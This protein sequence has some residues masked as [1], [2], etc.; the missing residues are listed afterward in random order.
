MKEETGNDRPVCINYGC[1]KF[2]TYSVKGR[3]RPFCGRCHKAGFG[4]VKQ[5]RYQQ[6]ADGSITKYESITTYAD[7]VTPFKTGK[8]TNKGVLDLGF[9]CPMDYKKAPWAIGRTELDHKDG[10][11]TNNTIENIQELCSV[12]H[13]EK[14]R[15]N[16]DYKDQNNYKK[17]TNDNGE[18]RY[19]KIERESKSNALPI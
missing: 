8:C 9:T 10:D 17:Y 16:G 14:S 5:I 7:G 1:E 2:C 3:F 19:Y 12:C 11:Y 6:L 15:R 4:H 13:V 18:L